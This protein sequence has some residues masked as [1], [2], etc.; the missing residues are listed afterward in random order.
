MTQP[1]DLTTMLPPGFV[2]TRTQ[3]DALFAAYQTNGGELTLAQAL[4]I[5][6]PAPA[7]PTLLGPDPDIPNG[8]F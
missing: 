6:G 4:V 7:F 2:A 3:Q 5:T 1:F 8:D